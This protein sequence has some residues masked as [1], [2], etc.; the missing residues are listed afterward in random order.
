MKMKM[1]I[2]DN[3]NK[4]RILYFIILF[5]QILKNI[6]SFYKLKHE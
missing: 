3:I 1:K 2:N 4:L 5:I 6:L